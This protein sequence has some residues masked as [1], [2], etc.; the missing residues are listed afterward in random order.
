MLGQW[1]LTRNLSRVKP[2][3]SDSAFPALPYLSH[4]DIEFGWTASPHGAVVLLA[5]KEAINDQAKKSK[6]VALC[7]TDAAS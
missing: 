6:P 5:T 1:P 2:S 7:A 4:R 3:A